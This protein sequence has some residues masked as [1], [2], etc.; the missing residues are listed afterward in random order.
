MKRSKNILLISHCLLNANA[1]VKGLANYEASLK[2]LVIPLLEKDISIIQL[3]C[4]EFSALGA[5]RWGQ[6]KDQY[7]NTFY[8][9]HC[10]EILLKTC[11]EVSEYVQNG[12]NV[13]GVIG[14]DYSPSCGVN[15][16][17]KGD[18]GGEFDDKINEI[19][20]TLHYEKDR[21]V[22][23]QTLKNMLEKRGVKLKFWGID[24]LNPKSSCKNILK[25]IL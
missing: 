5:K 4:P 9:N 17:C 8:I 12:Y 24:E 6:T 14:V 21:G 23:M 16:T 1:K 19:I 15:L 22:F 13:L 2:E 18:W 3:P 20:S 7:N 11:D 25:E 10:K